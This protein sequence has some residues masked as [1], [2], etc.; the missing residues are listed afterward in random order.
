MVSKM[1]RWHTSPPGL[2][3]TWAP[4][5]Q[6]HSV[7]SAQS[8]ADR[9]PQA[10]SGGTDA[11]SSHQRYPVDRAGGT[12]S[13]SSLARRTHSCLCLQSR[14]LGSCSAHIWKEKWFVG[15]WEW[16]GKVPIQAST[17]TRKHPSGPHLFPFPPCPPHQQVLSAGITKILAFHF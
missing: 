6:G 8:Q 16:R 5:S 15:S 17:D 10:G 13:H 4:T 3:L 1:G 2:P 11:G 12:G 14:V 7:D 9:P